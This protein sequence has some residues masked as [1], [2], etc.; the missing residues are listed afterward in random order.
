MNNFFQNLIAG[1]SASRRKMVTVPSMLFAASLLIALTISQAN[2]QNTVNGDGKKGIMCYVCNSARDPRCGDPFDPATIE[3][4]DCEQFMPNMN[5]TI[6]RKTVQRAVL[7][8][9]NDYRVVR[10]C[11]YSLSLLATALKKMRTMMGSQSD[12]STRP[13]PSKS[14]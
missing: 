11:G 7:G 14:S 13:E 12:V 9:R 6:C 5:T 2:G 3:K 10:T 4:V 1:L 8:S